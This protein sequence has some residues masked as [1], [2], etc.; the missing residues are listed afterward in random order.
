MTEKQDYSIH[1]TD[2]I[3]RDYLDVVDSLDDW[4]LIEHKGFYSGGSGAIRYV[5]FSFS[6]TESESS[7]GGNF[8]YDNTDSAHLVARTPTELIDKCGIKAATDAAS[9][10][11]NQAVAAARENL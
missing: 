11:F 8:V 4:P 7:A 5:T 1:L 2:I 10:S 9:H 6:W 3:R